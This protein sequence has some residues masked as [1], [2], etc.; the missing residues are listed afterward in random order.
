MGLEEEQRVCDAVLCFPSN[1]RKES[2]I[3]AA[4]GGEKGNGP[5]LSL[6]PTTT[7]L[8]PSK[9]SGSSDASTSLFARNMEPCLVASVGVGEKGEDCS[10]TQ[11]LSVDQLYR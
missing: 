10:L 1:P 6:P 9:S 4:G 2:S 3:T 7:L 11:P 5:A 8:Q